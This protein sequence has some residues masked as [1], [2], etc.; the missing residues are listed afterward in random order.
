MSNVWTPG[1]LNL[2]W[3]HLPQGKMMIFQTILHMFYTSLRATQ[4]GWV[5]YRVQQ[6]I[7]WQSSRGLKT[8]E[9]EILPGTEFNTE[10]WPG[11]LEKN[12]K[13]HD[14]QDMYSLFCIHVSRHFP[15]ND[16]FTKGLNATRYNAGI[17]GIRHATNPF[18]RER[19]QYPPGA[20]SFG[21]WDRVYSCLF[22]A[23]ATI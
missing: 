1:I 14:V 10:N 20:N 11:N 8:R 19:V 4:N 17:R 15:F 9:H 23:Y 12:P 2:F 7:E 21:A 18:L 22:F 13:T 16:S 6:Q 3:G 5:L